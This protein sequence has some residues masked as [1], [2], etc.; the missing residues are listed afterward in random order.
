MSSAAIPQVMA[1]ESAKN[2][3]RPK[4]RVFSGALDSVGAVWVM[5]MDLPFFW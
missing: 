3:P 4:V 2:V 5:A 1:N